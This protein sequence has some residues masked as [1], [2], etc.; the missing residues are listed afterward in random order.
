MDLT[1]DVLN[2]SMDFMALG[3]QAFNYEAISALEIPGTNANGAQHPY[4]FI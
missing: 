1:N 2:S 4:P 3:D